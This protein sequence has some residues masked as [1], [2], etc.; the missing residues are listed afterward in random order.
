MSMVSISNGTWRL[1]LSEDGHPMGLHDGS[2]RLDV[3]QKG[4]AICELL[5][6]TPER[7]MVV[8]SARMTR[9]TVSSAC[10]ETVLDLGT[11]VSLSFSY[12]IRE[13]DDHGTVVLC[14][15]QL[16]PDLLLD[17]DLLLRWFWGVRLPG[18]NSTLFAPLFDGRGL[19]TRRE[20]RQGWHYVCAGGWGGGTARLAVPMVDEGSAD[21]RL[22]VAY[23]ADPFFSMGITLPP[24]ESPELFQCR[25]LKDAG[26]RQF[27][28]RTFGLYLH[29][30]DAETALDGFFRYGIENSP[31]GP[32]WLHDIAMVHYDFF[33]ENGEGWFRDT[34][35]LVELFGAEDR[36]RI[37]LTLHGCYDFLGRY[38][39]DQKREQLDQ[40][41][42]VMQGTGGAEISLGEI[43]RR[44]AYAKERGFRV[45]L[46]FADG[47]A[48]DSAA[49]NYD[50]SLVFREQDGSLRRHY[51]SGP[52][53][54]AQT[55]IM[56]P[57]NPRVQD[58]FRGYMGALLAEFGGEID[59]LNWDE[60]FTIKTND[61]SRG[62]TSGYASRAF[63]LLCKELREMVKARDPELVF[64]ASD[65][66]Q[67][68]LPLEDGT[69]W[70]VNTAQNALVFDGTYQDSQCYPAAWQYGLFP[71]Y[72]NVLWSCNWKPVENFEWTKL[73]VRAFGAPVAISNGWGENKGISRY[74]EGEVRKLMQLFEFR[75]GERS[76]VRWLECRE[77]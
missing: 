37:A 17:T 56:D 5:F 69:Y 38:C 18:Q 35:K 27:P 25:F 30:G 10:F 48:I 73:G 55:Y 65:C 14:R 1:E 49:P 36:A 15:V 16:S 42:T 58:F 9:K 74:S 24:D 11:R 67:L 53:T 63:M 34:D 21:S 54:S 6:G 32:A 60:T 39:F 26:A 64:L 61:I 43:H 3:R 52:D 68:S 50:K 8:A 19:R 59:G 40:K 4:A 51:W 20:K 47:L 33:S 62:E 57:L 77:L 46:Y 12:E 66:T 45:L 44:L 41:W 72:R 76:G 13:P 31:P 29:S 28:E 2:T 7:E 70:S 71:N 75:K 23:F 22:H